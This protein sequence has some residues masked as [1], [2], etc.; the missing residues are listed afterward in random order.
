M[1]SESLAAG[2][3]S[4]SRSPRL[5]CLHL[6]REQQFV[7]AGGRKHV[8]AAHRA[9]SRDDAWQR[10]HRRAGGKTQLFESRE[11]PFDSSIGCRRGLA[12]RKR[13]ED[14]LDGGQVS[15]LEATPDA[16]AV[17]RSCRES[18]TTRTVVRPSLAIRKLGYASLADQKRMFMTELAA[19]LADAV[20]RHWLAKTRAPIGNG[21]CAKSSR[22]RAAANAKAA[23]TVTRSSPPR[24]P[25]QRCDAAGAPRPIQGTYVARVYQRS[26]AT[27]SAST[28]IPRRTRPAVLLPR[29]AK[30]IA[31][32]AR[33]VVASFVEAG[34]SKSPQY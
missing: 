13:A 15:G 8:F 33:T 17:L 26:A 14:T 20:K 19:E 25:R 1:R 12:P 10:R 16:R 21:W 7:A 3:Q 6:L 32:T 27:N 29:D 22:R 34:A 30:L 9:E 18:Q 28:R 2:S 23:A 4:A 24:V 11:R 31:D 5:F